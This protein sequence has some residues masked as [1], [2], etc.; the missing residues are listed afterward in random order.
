MYSR[1]K[2]SPKK[3]GFAKSKDSAS[4]SNSGK[5]KDNRYSEIA[6]VIE[7]T[8]ITLPVLKMV[9]SEKFL[10]CYRSG[11]YYNVVL[12]SMFIGSSISS[13]IILVLLRPKEE[14][15]GIEDLDK[16]QTELELMLSNVVLRQR[17]LHTEI[18]HISAA[19]ET[20]SKRTASLS[21]AKIVII[22]ELFYI[23][24]KLSTQ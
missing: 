21:I 23:S 3:Y 18:T 24:S 22:V 13:H 6:P 7:D 5:L 12:L 15:V 11:K 1:S 14:C 19:E 9:D 10:Q 20:K 17:I 16:L 2:H 8:E 4:T